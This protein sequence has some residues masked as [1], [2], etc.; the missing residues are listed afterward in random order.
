MKNQ[1][2]EKGNNVYSI[3]TGNIEYCFSS[4]N[5]LADMPRFIETTISDFKIP[6]HLDANDNLQT[7]FTHSM[8]AKGK[9]AGIMLC[10]NPPKN[11]RAL[12]SKV[13]E[14][15]NVINEA[16]AKA[17]EFGYIDVE[18]E[19][20]TEDELESM[21]SE[22]TSFYRKQIAGDTEETT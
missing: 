3:S 10:T 8:F 15:L 21:A 6:M 7:A 22:I 14:I 19:R 11:K 16:I 5:E 12:K 1:I 13:F 17:A 18:F 4:N 9:L 20:P 2:Q